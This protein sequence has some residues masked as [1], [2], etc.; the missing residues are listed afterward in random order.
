MVKNI[1][2][3]LQTIA[4]VSIGAL[5]FQSD[6]NQEK[7]TKS[8]EQLEKKIAKNIRE[9]KIKANICDIRENIIRVKQEIKDMRIDLKSILSNAKDENYV[10]ILQSTLAQKEI[11]VLLENFIK[12]K[13]VDMQVTYLKYKKILEA[14]EKLK[15]NFQ[16]LKDV[17]DESEVKE[18]VTEEVVLDAGTEEDDNGEQFVEYSYME[19]KSNEQNTSLKKLYNQLGSELNISKE[20]FSEVVYTF[21]QRVKKQIEGH[22]KIVIAYTEQQG[23]CLNLKKVYKLQQEKKQLDSRVIKKQARSV[24]ECYETLETLVYSFD[25]LNN[26]FIRL[27]EVIPNIG[28]LSAKDIGYIE[29]IKK[30]ISL[31]Q[32]K[33]IGIKALLK[34]DIER[35]EKSS[36][37]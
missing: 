17:I 27:K 15:E 24:I 9:S 30:G 21:A 4:L 10:P 26:D 33:L 36:N 2:L 20:D 13:D 28:S 23:E 29:T 5:Y 16:S 6:F 3:I 25:E 19:I 14:Y 34:L 31:I 37:E 22:R 12:K 32:A 35:L 1:I 11:C 7:Q 18:K 8:I